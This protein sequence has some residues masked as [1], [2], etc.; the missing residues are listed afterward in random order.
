MYVYRTW[1]SWAPLPLRLIIGIGMMYHGW[2]KLFDAQQHA[3]FAGNLQALGFPAP[4]ALAWLV[5]LL[6]VFGGLALILGAFVTILSVL[7]IIEMLV[8]MFTVHLPAGFSFMHITGMSPQGPTFG[9]P[10][11]EVNLLYIAGLLS[12]IFSGAG[13]YSVDEAMARRRATARTADVGA[14]P[15]TT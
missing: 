9:L 12:L 4:G 14:R 3:G 7:F 15:A 5:G 6:E 10:G 2:P 11:Y 1:P 8:A 13:A